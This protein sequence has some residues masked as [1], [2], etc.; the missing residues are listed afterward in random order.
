MRH[1]RHAADEEGEGY[2]ASVSDLMVGILF[3][4]LL[5]LTVFAVNYHQAEQKQLVQRSLYERLVVERSNCKCKN[6]KRSGRRPKR[7]P[8]GTAAFR[9]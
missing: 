9:C 7:I 3:V 5:M 6:L 4:F 2:F 1:P 8:P